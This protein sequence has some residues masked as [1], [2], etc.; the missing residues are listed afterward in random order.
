MLLALSRVAADHPTVTEIDV[1]P[2]I[3]NA[4]GVIAVDALIVVDQGAL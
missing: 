4:D 3:L 2:L 1:N